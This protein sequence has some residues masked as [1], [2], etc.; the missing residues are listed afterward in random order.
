MRIIFFC[1]ATVLFSCS[2][3]NLSENLI[4]QKGQQVNEFK[5]AVEKD[6]VEKIV[7]DFS[8]PVSTRSYKGTCK[9]ATIDTISN[10]Q[11]TTRSN[12]GVDTPRNL[13]YLVKLEN[14]SLM[15]IG[16]DKR[17]EPLYASFDNLDL[18]IDN[19]GKLVSN[20][21]IPDMVVGLLENFIVDVKNK[22]K[23]NNQINS[24]YDNNRDVATR[25]ITSTGDEVK[26]KLAYRFP[27][28]FKFNAHN[29]TY[30]LFYSQDIKSWTIHALCVAIPDHVEI[31]RFGNYK[32]K[33]SW[34]K[35]KKL[36]VNQ[37]SGDMFDDFVNMRERIPF[38]DRSNPEDVGP[39]AFSAASSYLSR[40]DGI[41]SLSFDT[42][43]YNM[44]NNLRLET[45]IS[46]VYGYRDRKHPTFFRHTSY[47]N[48]GIFL[49]D[50]FKKVRDVYYIHVLGPIFDNGIVSGYVLD[51]NRA[52][53][54]D[55]QHTRWTE[56][57]G[58]PYKTGTLNIH[59]TK[60]VPK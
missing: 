46:Y 25:S 36:N 2:R 38:Y 21:S 33:A 23:H 48:F 49:A 60:Y 29:N 4:D 11:V 14:G 39:I 20:D 17:A 34:K 42:D 53:A 13:L 5:F 45:G 12:T 30:N 37:L 1:L 3:E 54:S 55:P 41:P 9:I 52:N 32:L 31:R 44:L 22:V 35:A 50:G 16:G 19:E 6:D 59:T 10:N 43:W 51:F 40:A 26:P 7:R 56:W 24:Y 27:E 18:R 57:F 8:Q 47:Y 58:T 28:S 15:I